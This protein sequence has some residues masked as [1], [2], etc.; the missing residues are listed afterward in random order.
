VKTRRSSGFRNLLWQCKITEIN[1]RCL[2]INEDHNVHHLHKEGFKNLLAGFN[3]FI[4]ENNITYDHEFGHFKI[5]SNVA[6]GSTDI[7]RT[8]ASFYGNE[9]FSNLAIFTEDSTWYGKVYIYIY[10]FY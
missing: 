10:I 4:E 3:E 9:W 1:T 8:A 7:I 5:Y 2:Q 6:V